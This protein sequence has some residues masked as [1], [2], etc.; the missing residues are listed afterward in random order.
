MWS[1][2]KKKTLNGSHLQKDT[3]I[4]RARNDIIKRK[5]GFDLTPQK[6]PTPNFLKDDYTV[7]ESF[8]R[9]NQRNVN[10]VCICS[11]GQCQL[12]NCE[13]NLY[14]QSRNRVTYRVQCE[15]T[16]MSNG[17]MRFVMLR[18]AFK[19]NR[20][21]EWTS[22]SIFNFQVFDGNT[23]RFTV[24]SH[25]LKI[26]HISKCVRINPITWQGYISLR[27]EFY[28]CREGND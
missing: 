14:I 6:N 23:D 4:R 18:C 5:H 26:P 7:T 3:P 27:A 13:T 16:Y 17:K 15:V 1:L 19:I 2:R 12:V 28:G 11:W 20:I 24:V 10:L 9:I 25:D 22:T 21:G 8:Q